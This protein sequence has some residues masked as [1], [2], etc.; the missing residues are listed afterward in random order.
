MYSLF[1]F[2]RDL[3]LIDNT[4]LLYALKNYKNVIPIFIY[5][6]EQIGDK[7]KYRSENAILFM[8]ECLEELL[9]EC[10]K[11]N[12]YL[13]RFYGT[14]ID[15]LKKIIKNIEIENIVTNMDYT[16][17]AIKRDKE[18]SKLCKD[19]NINFHHIEDYLLAPIGTFCKAN[20]GD[21]KEPYRVF[22]PFK[23][24]LYSNDKYINEPNK[25]KSLFKNLVESK[26]K[27]HKI[28][29]DMVI[30]KSI[31]NYIDY[32]DKDKDKDKD[33]D[34]SV[35]TKT[36]IKGGRKN[37]LKKIS[38]SNINKHKNYNIDRQFM[39][40]DT[41]QLSAYIKF[42]CI[43]VREVFYRF[44]EV[45]GYKNDLLSQLVW[46]EF[47]FYIGYYFPHVLKGHNYNRNMDHIN[48]KWVKSKLELNAWRDGHTGYPIVDAGMRE[49]NATGY[50]HNRSRL[51]TANFLNRILG[52]DWRRGEE[53]FAK[54]LRDYDPLVNNGNWQWISSTGVDTKP[55]SQRVFNPWSQ[56][57]RY[58]PDC[59]YIKKWIPEL[60]NVENNHIHNWE[61]H[62]DKEE[63]KNINYTSPIVD[64]KK[65][66]ER[67]LKMYKK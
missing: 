55:S 3:R 39:K 31:G 29:M 12:S 41:T 7:N 51:I 4:G 9:Q 17:Y 21:V 36:I 46:R 6:P 14:N 50:M 63:Y 45:L 13:Y 65:A 35:A 38:V 8:N 40:N 54:T 42:G 22:T 5:T 59:V 1:I 11:Y 37:A 67:S 28:L 15:V 44:K 32:T 53:Y 57:E 58:D 30:K 49:L 24:Y 20:S 23:N 27:Y 48:K 18:I 2:R 34:T 33:K 56:S 62:F 25:K 26:G 19:N 43:S 64:Y 66:R 61:L 47:Y 10:K 60:K 16:P 52:Q